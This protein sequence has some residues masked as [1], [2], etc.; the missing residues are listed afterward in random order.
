MLDQ[1]PDALPS[2][3]IVAVPFHRYRRQKWA[4]TFVAP[5]GSVVRRTF[6]AFQ[7]A[8]SAARDL[9]LAGRAAVSA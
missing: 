9:A 6:P 5:G 3:E 8:V 4:M 1:R 7:D 2:V